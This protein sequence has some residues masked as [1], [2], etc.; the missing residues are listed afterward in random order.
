M[1]RH[2]TVRSGA[3]W[4]FS[5]SI[6]GTIGYATAGVVFRRMFNSFDNHD[7]AAPWLLAAPLAVAAFVVAASV[8]FAVITWLLRRLFKTGQ[9]DGSK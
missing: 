8:A 7:S 1:I 2:L 3:R 9:K 6:A 5:A 4:L